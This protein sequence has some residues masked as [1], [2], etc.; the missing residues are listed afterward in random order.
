[1][2]VVGFLLAVIGFA[3]A[4]AI[5]VR[6]DRQ[7]KSEAALQEALRAQAQEAD[8]RREASDRERAA[9][10]ARVA[11][12]EEELA[13]ATARQDD[14]AVADAMWR[15][16][17]ERTDR[18][19][20]D[21]IVP[22]G[23]ERMADGTIG[24]DLALAIGQEVERLREEVGVSIR[25]D[26]DL[27][28]EMGPQVA[29]GA[30]RIVEEVLALAA[31]RADEIE[32]RLREVVAPPSIEIVLSCEG[33]EGHDAASEALNET[34]TA[35]AARLDGVVSWTTASDGRVQVAIDL[36]V[37]SVPEGTEV[38]PIDVRGA[39]EDGA[40]DGDVAADA[41]ALPLQVAETA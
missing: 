34:V 14:A 36:P 2:V 19:W 27:R 38:E 24:T 18:Q 22:S 32:V 30:L 7:R 12:L 37:E 5:W 3:L 29:L 23:A 9:T 16:E 40:V 11:E 4:A 28:A 21:I 8:V 10:S 31:K 41:A 15:L 13:E 35:M 33:W 26:G 39:E 25:K 17:L 1:M 20:R 6:S